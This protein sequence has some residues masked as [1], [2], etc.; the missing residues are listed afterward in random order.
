MQDS[1]ELQPTTPKISSKMSPKGIKVQ[2]D[3]LLL[4]EF[5]GT[6]KKGKEA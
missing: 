1:R 4:K 2:M 5:K 3:P 6:V